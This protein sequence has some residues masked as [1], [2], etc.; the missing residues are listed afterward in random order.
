MKVKNNSSNGKSRKSCA[1][2]GL[3]DSKIRDSR[4]PNFYKR[5]D[6]WGTTELRHNNTK[7]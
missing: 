7:K 1:G 2:N 3:K 4:K 6:D 5:D